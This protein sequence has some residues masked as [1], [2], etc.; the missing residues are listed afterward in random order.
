MPEHGL[1]HLG[2]GDVE[3]LAE[4]VFEGAHDLTPVL[5][6]LGVLDADFE[7]QLGDGHDVTAVARPV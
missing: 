1:V 2:D 7:G 3:A 5:E 6:G 4:L